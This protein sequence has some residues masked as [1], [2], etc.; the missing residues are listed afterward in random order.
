M[1]TEDSGHRGSDLRRRFH[2][3][4]DTGTDRLPDEGSAPGEGGASEGHGQQSSQS[5]GAP[6][7]LARDT[8][9]RLLAARAR[10]RSELRQALLRKGIEDDIAEGVL[11]KFEDAGLVDD[12]AFAESWVRQRHEYQGLGRRALS[13]ELRRKGVDDQ[14]VVE[15]LSG[16]DADAEAQR[17]RELVRRKLRGMRVDDPT[18]RTRRLVA[19]L[20]RKGYS[21]ALAFRVVREETEDSDVD[22]MEMDGSEFGDRDG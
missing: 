3:D 16:V 17:A 7:Q 19:M 8:V 11:Q 5:S 14:A 9:Y 4:R 2:G 22:A 6:E 10:S 20:A 12:A 15:A 18:T 21:E 1:S 13:A